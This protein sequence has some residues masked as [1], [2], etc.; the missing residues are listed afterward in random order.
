MSQ[1]MTYFA[2]T[3][4][5][6]EHDPM[7]IRG[8]AALPLSPDLTEDE[9]LQQAAPHIPS[10]CRA[11]RLDI[12]DEAWA[13]RPIVNPVLSNGAIIQGPSPAIPLKER[14][15]TAMQQ[16]QQQAA[17]TSAMGET[18]GPQMQAYVR[19]LRDIINGTDTSSTELPAAPAS[20]TQ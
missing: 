7:P 5:K 2:I 1:T 17:M 4:D 3:D 15:T 11:V 14:A 13:T 20:P 9:Q 6:T 19:A 10:G 16:V 12:T 18:F 8:W